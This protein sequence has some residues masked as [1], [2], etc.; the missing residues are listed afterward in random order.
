MLEKEKGKDVL[1]RQVA[2]IMARR[3]ICYAK[4][5]DKVNQGEEMGIIR[6][7]SRVDFFLPVDV[8]V[9]VKIGE[10]VRAQLSII[11]EF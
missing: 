11:A 1:I 8:N 4:S 6:F 10:T 9:K 5:N 3:I 7:G 2:G